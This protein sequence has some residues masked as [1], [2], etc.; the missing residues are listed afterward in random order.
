M[1]IAERS[2]KQQ[3]RAFLEGQHAMY[4]DVVLQQ[5]SDAPESRDGSRRRSVKRE[6]D[7]SSSSLSWFDEQVAGIDEDWTTAASL[8]ELAEAIDGCRGCKL[9]ATR[10]NLVFGTGDPNA[11][12][13]VV[14][15]APGADEDAQGKPFIGRAGQLLTKILAAIDLDRDDVYIANIIK[16]RPPGNRR[17]ESDEVE[18]CLPYLFKQ[19]ALVRPR[20]ILALGLTAA[21]SLIGVQGPMKD[22]R[23]KMHEWHGIPVIITYHPAALLR[24]PNWKRPT[25]DDMKMLRSLLDGENSTTETS[26]KTS[27]DQSV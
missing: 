9:G 19:I 23:G 8:A 12:L 1:S 15:E 20:Y 17:P 7:H 27:D 18:A 21:K 6:E 11:D 3:A 24:N 5:Q 2:L 16:S 4:G 26:A 10:T 22:L 14:G 13:M 25:W